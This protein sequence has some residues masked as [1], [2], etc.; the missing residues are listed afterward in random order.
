MWQDQRKYNVENQIMLN[1]QGKN[2]VRVSGKTDIE[3]G[4]CGNFRKSKC[5]RTR[6]N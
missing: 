4:Q 2:S 1:G 3:W 5:T 6:F